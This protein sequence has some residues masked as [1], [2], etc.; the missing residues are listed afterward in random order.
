MKAR[1]LKA[2]SVEELRSATFKNLQLYRTDG[3]S[4]LAADG[5]FWFE[6]S[7]QVDEE[8]IADLAVPVGDNLF[9]VDNCEKIYDGIKGITPYEAR[10]ERFWCY[11]S[12]TL[13]LDH[14]RA[15]WPIP[16]DDERAVKHIHKHFFAGDKR[17]IE[18]E[19]VGA[20]LWWMAHLCGRVTSVS[21]NDA[22]KTFLFRSDVRANLI[23]RPT[24]SQ[25]VILFDAIIAKLAKSYQGSQALFSRLVFRKLMKEINSV[26]GY[27]LL[28]CLSP[29]S[30]EAILDDI[31]QQKLNL[32]AT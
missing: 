31:I 13:L 4:Y 23:E 1:F 21:R 15:R 6:Q 24:T 14:A 28:D 2:A 32:T 3:F 7:F 17:G 10:D 29:S 26:G 9:E 11:L 16:A 25:S 27:K 12:H 8:A 19:N 18:R 22:L 5:A 30:V 20:R